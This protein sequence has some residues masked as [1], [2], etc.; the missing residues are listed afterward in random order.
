MFDK[1]ILT[2]Q[3]VETR[4]PLKNNRKVMRTSH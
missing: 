4:N 3:N 2:T 1:K